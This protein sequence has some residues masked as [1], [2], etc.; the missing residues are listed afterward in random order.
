M[1][2][3]YEDGLLDDPLLFDQC[4]SFVGGQ[5]SFTRPHLIQE[6]QAELLVNID[7]A[8]NGIARTRRGTEDRGS[9]IV[10]GKVVQ[11]LAY[12]D[13]SSL[14]YLI[15]C[16][17]RQMYRW[18]GAAWLPF[19]S[20]IA[21]NDT[22]AVEMAVG[23]NTL[24]L[25]DGIG[26]VHS[27]DGTTLVD[28]GSGLSSQPPV[29]K[30]LLWFTNRL[31]AA[32][33][34]NGDELYASDFLDGSTWDSSFQSIRI[35]AGEGDPITAL[36]GWID[37]RIVVGKRGSIWVVHADPL[38]SGGSGSMAE[39]TVTLVH[40]R[41]G[42]VAHRTMVQV[43]QDVWFLSDTGVRSVGKTAGTDLNAVGPALSYPVQD[44][45]DRINW[46]HADSSC[47]VFWNNRYLLSIPLDDATSPNYVLVY[48]TDTASW[49]GYWTGWNARCFAITAFDGVARLA[50]GRD[51]CFVR[52]WMDYVSDRIA[53]PNTYLDGGA[54]YPSEIL[55]RALTFSEPLNPKLGSHVE[56]EFYESDADANLEAR[57]DQAGY[58]S[59][60]GFQA[61]GA[62]NQL[63]L[64]LP[65]DL[66]T[67][68]TVRGTVD[69]MQYGTWREIQFRLSSVRGKLSVRGI[70]AAA[71]LDTLEL[72]S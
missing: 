6:T 65:F 2:L 20:Y 24:Y 1:P 31:F 5:V 16:V 4:A 33:I 71:F 59:V 17:D 52:Q 41:I 46:S 57:L 68:G 72:E 8:Q 60:S 70:L 9:A 58:N 50:F 13:S 53:T 14:E 37:D 63:P 22:A 18:D 66:P 55:T 36:C 21:A 38:S 27:W 12:Y 51:D 62:P 48:N 61:A 32:G 45:I 15:A 43:G 39:W 30:Y 3:L 49:S 44:V 19:S 56:V 28:L 7:I 29:C 67:L 40:R 42:C 69:L 23:I 10:A 35:G 54:I 47:A 25:T 11:G 34:A 26:N 64:S